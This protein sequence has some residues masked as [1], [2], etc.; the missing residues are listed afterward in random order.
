MSQKR[1]IQSLK[2]TLK[3]CSSY[4]ELPFLGFRIEKFTVNMSSSIKQTA[5]WQLLP[6]TGWF[7]VTADLYKH[8]EQ[9]SQLDHAISPLQRIWHQF[10][11]QLSWK[12]GN[13]V[14]WKRQR[15][16]EEPSLICMFLGFNCVRDQTTNIKWTAKC[17]LNPNPEIRPIKIHACVVGATNPPW[18]S[19]SPCCIEFSPCT[20]LILLTKS[21]LSPA[22]LPPLLSKG[23]ELDLSPNE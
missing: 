19:D 5:E 4:M 10:L 2:S 22:D 14:V 17:K 16:I 21:S 13:F 1:S 18:T 23:A 7:F 3:M 6:G 15:D 11:V 12:P 8:L 20:L 9:L